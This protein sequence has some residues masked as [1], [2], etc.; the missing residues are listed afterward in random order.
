MGG[1]FLS[2]KVDVFQ[3]VRA[4]A[5]FVFVEQ[6]SN[7]VQGKDAGRAQEGQNYGQEQ[8]I[9]RENKAHRVE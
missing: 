5:G 9:D 8:I 6:M 3:F 2:L 7:D 4:P 1:S